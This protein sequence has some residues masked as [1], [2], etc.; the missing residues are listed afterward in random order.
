MP[1]T[2]YKA[3]WA[4]WDESWPAP[5]WPLTQNDGK[6]IGRGTIARELI[7]PWKEFEAKGVGVMVG[8]FGAHNLSPHRFVSPG[9]TTRSKN[10]RRPAGAGPCGTSPEVSASATAVAMTSRSKTGTA[11]S[12]T[13]ACSNCCRRVDLLDGAVACAASGRPGPLQRRLCTSG[14]VQA[15]LPANDGAER[16]GDLTVPRYRSLPSIGRIAVDVVP[17]AMPVEH[18][19]CRFQLADQRPRFIRPIPPEVA[20]PS[21]GQVTDRG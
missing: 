3:S 20:G 12:W 6:V 2:H 1:L 10:S 5:T 17:L 13:E 8:E 4:N 21:P 16:V 11:A 18:T 7:K 15:E 19:P 14:L 9:C